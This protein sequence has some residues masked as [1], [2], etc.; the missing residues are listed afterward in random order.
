MEMYIDEVQRRL[1]MRW[2]E[3]RC[4]VLG[5]IGD[6]NLH[7]FITPSA[8]A[9]DLHSQVDQAVYEPLSAY[10]G[11]V[12]AEHGIGLEKKHWLNACRTE[13]EL[14]LMRQLKRSLDPGNLLNPGKVLDP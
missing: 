6:G 10:Q 11:S 2:P 4:Y 3:S 5:H 1:K 9:D 12:S 14:A 7:L 8:A 13:T